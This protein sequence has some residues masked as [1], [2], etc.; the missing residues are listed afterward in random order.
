M[1]TSFLNL[2]PET[3]VEGGLIDDVNAT[4]TD[5]KFTMFDYNGKSDKGASPAL[6]LELE[7]E[8]G[9]KHEQYYS[10]GDAKYWAPG[11]DGK[12][13]VP[14]GD[15]T[16][17]SKSCKLA[18]FLSALMNAGFPV[19]KLRGGDISCLTGLKAHFTRVADKERKGLVRDANAQAQSTLV[20]T[21]IIA[22]PGEQ[23]KQPTA[24]P[25]AT[26][27]PGIGGAS[28]SATTTSTVSDDDV[29]GL[30]LEI[31]TE[32]GGSIAKNRISQAVFKKI[33]KS[34]S[35]FSQRTGVTQRSIQDDFL[36]SGAEHG[37]WE[38]D[39]STVKIA[40]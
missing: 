1:A 20:I 16:A 14:T 21:K 31:V 7:L 9:V 29:T 36:K 8:D 6:G 37:L 34:H 27:A 39:G 35:L 10:A 40:G 26:G 19:D 28:T 25:V 30:V 18:V 24:K 32:S 13:L 22:M 3:F 38:F 12:T 4:I 15:K 2:A 5:A 11:A 23:P 33:D 17:L